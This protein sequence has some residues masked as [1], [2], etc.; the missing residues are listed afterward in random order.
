L[1]REST[2][3]ED[4]D[5]RLQWPD[6]QDERLAWLHPTDLVRAG[7]RLDAAEI[8]MRH[9][10]PN[11][12]HIFADD[13]YSAAYYSYLWADTRCQDGPPTCAASAARSRSRTA[14]E[15]TIGGTASSESGRN[16]PASSMPG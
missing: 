1:V 11:Y 15:N 16:S 8:V 7:A 9:R 4:D 10:I 14:S 3:L 13:G 2:L 12:K 5:R 6:Q